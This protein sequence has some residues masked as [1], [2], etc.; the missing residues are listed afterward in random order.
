MYHCQRR[1]PWSACCPWRRNLPVREMDSPTVT[2]VLPHIPY[3]GGDLWVQLIQH[4][5][6]NN[7]SNG[8]VEPKR[9]CPA[10]DSLLA[11]EPATPGPIQRD[12]GQGHDDDRENCVRTEQRQI[13]D[14]HPTLCGEAGDTL[15]SVVPN[16]ADQKK[17]GGCK[18]RKH[19]NLVSPDFLTTNEEIAERQ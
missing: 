13:K 15:V 4:P 12:Q 10:S 14:T 5:V 11:I 2:S 1:M 17:R 18:R 7:A 3:R 16:I 9:E 19:A 6:N 8:D